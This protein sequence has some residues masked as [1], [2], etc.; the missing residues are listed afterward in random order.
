MK[1]LN[2]LLSS[3]RKPPNAFCFMKRL[4]KNVHPKKEFFRLPNTFLTM[5]NLVWE[6]ITSDRKLYMVSQWA[7]AQL[8]ECAYFL[9]SYW[10]ISEDG[11]IIFSRAG[12]TFFYSIK[13]HFIL[14]ISHL[15]EDEHVLCFGELVSHYLGNLWPPTW[16]TEISMRTEENMR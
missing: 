9:K 12:K 7:W 3:F 10:R 5:K 2:Y 16:Q 4:K 6:I 14:L 8:F 13:L 11:Y 1:C 15:L